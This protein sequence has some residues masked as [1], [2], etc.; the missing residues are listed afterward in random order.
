MVRP[1]CLSGDFLR[2]ATFILQMAMKPLPS[3]LEREPLLDAVC[4]L[5]VTSRLPLIAMLPGYLHTKFGKE[6]SKVEN[7]GMQ[8]MVGLPPGLPPGFIGFGQQP[9]VRLAWRDNS[10][11]ITEKSVGL[12]SVL[13]YTGWKQFSQCIVELFENVIDSGLIDGIERYSVKYVNLLKSTSNAKPQEQLDW[14]LRVG[15]TQLEMGNVQLRSEMELNGVMTVVSLASDAQV[16]GPNSVGPTSGTIL[17][18]DTLCTVHIQDLKS[19]KN[20]LPERINTIRKMNKQT[21][22]NCLTSESINAMGPTYE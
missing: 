4:E 11:F 21:F 10:I 12:S 18:I 7:V 6:I 9:T 5:V 1:F 8:G 20:E 3:K 14:S 15:E 16:V 17:D 19:F 22:F 13:P 2:I